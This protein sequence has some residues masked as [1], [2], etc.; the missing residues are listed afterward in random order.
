PLEEL[1]HYLQQLADSVDYLAKHKV[2]HRDIKP[3]NILLR[4]GHAMLADFGLAEMMKETLH[5]KTADFAGTIAYTPPETF[6]GKI[7]P[8]SDQSSLA[9]TY[10]ELRTG[11]L[12]FPYDNITAIMY[13]HIHEV[14]KLEGLPEPE[15]RAL[16]VALSKDHRK[17]Y[18]NCM[19]FYRALD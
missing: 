19:K 6:Q 5:S 9:A 12:I 3:A 2:Q 1:L 15:Q 7:S 11:R 16:A 18:P 14:P 17:R 4:E 10:Y 8:T 13:A